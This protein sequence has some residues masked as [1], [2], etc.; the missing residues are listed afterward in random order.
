M[1]LLV[2]NRGNA[3]NHWRSVMC[4]KE[5]VGK[6]EAL[7][8]E[9]YKAMPEQVQKTYKPTWEEFIKTKDQLLVALESASKGRNA[10]YLYFDGLSEADK[11]E[12]DRENTIEMIVSR[13]DKEIVRF[14]L[15][16]T[17]QWIMQG[18]LKVYK[19]YNPRKPDPK[20]FKDNLRQ[21]ISKLVEAEEKE[22]GSFAKTVYPQ[23]S[24]RVRKPKPMINPDLA[25][26][27][28]SED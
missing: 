8:N 4:R 26:E 19:L 16:Y 25:V 5:L 10:G 12:E 22:P 3:S 23:K 24:V 28:D 9:L 7:F 6:M 21:A 13:G 14:T 18:D 17:M 2:T 20:H 1:S 15:D 11:D 27:D